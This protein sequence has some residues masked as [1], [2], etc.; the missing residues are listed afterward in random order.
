MVWYLRWRAGEDE[1][2]TAKDMLTGKE[3]PKR[4]PTDQGQQSIVDR[5]HELLFIPH[6]L[7]QQLAWENLGSL[8]LQS[9]SQATRQKK[10]GRTLLKAQ[11]EKYSPRVFEFLTKLKVQFASY[12]YLNLPDANIEME[13]DRQPKQ[14]EI[15]S[16]ILLFSDG[17]IQICHNHAG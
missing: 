14:A 6:F 2:P 9:P 10:V 13:R 15:V 12:L 4:R 16:I 8:Y 7:D 5:T 1:I 3:T 17:A 11:F